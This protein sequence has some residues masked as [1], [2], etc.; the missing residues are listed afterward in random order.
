MKFYLSFDQIY[1]ELGFFLKDLSQ[2]QS[3]HSERLK[4]SAKTMPSFLLSFN[5]DLF[6]VFFQ[7][8]R[9]FAK[10]ELPPDKSNQGYAPHV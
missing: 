9:F 4:G 1:Q 5:T 10:I 6:Q 2:S 7:L 8:S 3:F